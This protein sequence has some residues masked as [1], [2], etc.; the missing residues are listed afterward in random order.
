MFAIGLAAFTI[1]SLL[2]GV[3]GSGIELVIFRALQGIGGAVV[4]STSLA[5]LV[6]T[7]TGRGLGLAIGLWSAVINLGLGCGPV[8]GG[9]LTEASWRWIFFVNIPLAPPLSAS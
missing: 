7:F 3:A 8:L 1:G 6:Q 5:L 4:F 2:C 9:L